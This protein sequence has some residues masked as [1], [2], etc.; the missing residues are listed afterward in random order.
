MNKI[1]YFII[2]AVASVGLH[3]CQD[4]IDIEQ[5]G[6]LDPVAA[7]QDTDD[8][9]SF[10]IGTYSLLD[11]S[12][13]IGFT[14]AFTDEATRA[15]SWGGQWI[16][17]L[18]FLTTANSAVSSQFWI[19]NYRIVN[20]ANRLLTRAEE[21]RTELTDPA[22]V[23]QADIDRFNNV[24]AEARVARAWGHFQLTHYFSTDLTDDTALSVPV[25]DFVPGTGIQ[26]L[27]DTNEIAFNLIEEDL[28]FALTNLNTAS[29]ATFFSIDM[30]NAFRARI[31]NERGNYGEART[32]SLA[33]LASYPLVARDAYVDMFEDD[34]VGEVIFKLERVIGGPYDR[35]GSTGSAAAGGW[36]GANFAFGG[37]GIAG[38]PYMEVDRGLF[39][40]VGA[41]D[42][43]LL[44]MIAPSSLIDAAY[45]N[46]TSYREDDQLIV[47]KYRG[48]GGRNLMNDLKIFRSS[49]MLFIAAETY[50]R[51]N[52]LDAAA[53]LID[54]LNDARYP[55]DQQ[56]PNYTNSRE[57]LQDILEQ[58]RIELAFEGHRWKDI[59][60]I[61]V[62]ADRGVDRSPL[63]CEFNGD[64]QLAATSFLFALPIPLSE[65]NANPGIGQQQN[66]GYNND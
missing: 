5:P 30:V 42:V 21:L 55:T 65:I 43:R 40:L 23:D 53:L 16:Q 18:Q 38:S 14:A 29:S 36:A 26:P 37:P 59:K 48:S 35:Q 39:D 41:D 45:P 11:T 9:E 49:E 66:P 19:D 13:E 24:L 17:E 54:Q 52:D 20:Q 44:T 3:S 2:A 61:G 33:L 64:C 1:K 32:L 46:G 47:N 34:V 60:R 25:F 12:G 62:A 7:L 8:L 50:A 63:D 27:R 58:R 31:A 22:T 57:A 10:M 4:A 51:A 56:R 6:R 28:A 15:L